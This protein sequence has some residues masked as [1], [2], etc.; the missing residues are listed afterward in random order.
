MG[1]FGPF[2]R[3]QETY[4]LRCRLGEV[5]ESALGQV[6]SIAPYLLYTNMNDDGTP[7]TWQWLRLM[8]LVSHTSYAVDTVVG[9]GVRGDDDKDQIS[10]I[11]LYASLDR[12]DPLYAPSRELRWA[13][14]QFIDVAPV[15]V[16][17]GYDLQEWNRI[18]DHGA[19]FVPAR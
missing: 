6:D 17:S 1:K 10:W 9:Y 7:R 8:E 15:A 14:F 19:I 2:Y 4:E 3:F 16:V 12:C 5:F 11:S 13:V 18:Y